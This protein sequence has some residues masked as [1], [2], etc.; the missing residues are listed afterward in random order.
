[1]TR[2]GLLSRFRRGPS[3][4]T[5]REHARQLLASEALDADERDRVALLLS[6]LE[7]PEPRGEFPGRRTGI[8]DTARDEVKALWTKVHGT[9]PW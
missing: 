6:W 9:A 2:T 5:V 8:L 4:E 3:R 7:R 1:M